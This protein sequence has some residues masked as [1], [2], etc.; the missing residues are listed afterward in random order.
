[1]SIFC[2][3]CGLLLSAGGHAHIC[4]WRPPE[5]KMDPMPRFATDAELDA[6]AAVYAEEMTSR[7]FHVGVIERET[8]RRMAGIQ[9]VWRVAFARTLK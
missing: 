3:N 1:V 4:T 6:V 7:G 5:L 8:V 9:D 2:P